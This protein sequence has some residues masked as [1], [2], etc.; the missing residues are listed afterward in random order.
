MTKYDESIVNGLFRS[1]LTGRIHD[2]DTGEIVE[3]KLDKPYT[4]LQDVNKLDIIDE[5]IDYYK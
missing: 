2:R 4:P 1:I 5:I 3:T